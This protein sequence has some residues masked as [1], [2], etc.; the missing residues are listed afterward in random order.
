[1]GVFEKARETGTRKAFVQARI[2]SRK[3]SDKEIEEMKT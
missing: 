2:K 1:M 3:E